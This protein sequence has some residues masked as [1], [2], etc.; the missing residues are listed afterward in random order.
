MK[1]SKRV[2]IGILSLAVIASVSALSVNIDEIRSTSSEVIQF[3]SYSGP[4]AL[5]ES[6]DAITQIGRNLGRQVASNVNNG[7]TYG[8]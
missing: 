3:E 8:A 2:V 7:A 5:V 4:H 6:A 1:S